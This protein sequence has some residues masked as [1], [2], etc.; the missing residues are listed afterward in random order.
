MH[1]CINTKLSLPWDDSSNSFYTNDSH[2]DN[3][4]MATQ[5]LAAKPIP[6]INHQ[7][8]LSNPYNAAPQPPPLP[9]ILNTL[10]SWI[11]PNHNPVPP[12]IPNPIL[13]PTQI[14]ISMETN[15]APQSTTP[16][17]YQTNLTTQIHNHHWGDKMLLPKPMHTFCMLSCNI[18]TLSTQQ[19]YIQWKAASQALSDCEAD[20]IALQ[21]TN[22]PWNQINKQK[23]WQILK[24]PTGH[25][26]IATSSSMEISTQTHQW[27]GT[28]QGLVGSWVSH[29]VAS[30]KDTT[31]LGQWLYIKL[32]G[33]AN[34][35]YIILSGYGVCKNQQI[36]M[37]S[38]N[39]LNQQYWLLHQQGQQNPDPRS[40]FLD[41][42]ICQVKTWQEQQKAVLICID[43][44]ENP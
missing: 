35:C 38:K 43:A 32:Q 13:V 40:Q 41:D 27:G 1:I 18:N 37:G 14:T 39:T 7:P 2:N 16:Q 44:N 21:E 6:P 12:P 34:K 8:V 9:T 31:G 42:L 3:D 20:A 23:V 17:P 24:K 5:P 28:L 30:S 29:A 26:L 11:L 19:N 33:C 4:S 22:V 15:L 25:T 10:R 36:N